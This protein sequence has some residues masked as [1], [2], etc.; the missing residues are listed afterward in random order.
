MLDS[1]RVRLT[2]GTP[3][4]LALVLVVLALLTYFIFWRSTVQRTDVNISELSGPVLIS[5]SASSV[6]RRPRKVQKYSHRCAG[7]CLR[8]KIK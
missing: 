3:P 1:V 8:Q 5:T 7:R 4:F 2:F 6:V